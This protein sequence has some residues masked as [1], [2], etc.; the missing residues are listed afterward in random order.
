MA[1]SYLGL[2]IRSCDTDINNSIKELWNYIQ[3]KQ[4]NHPFKGYAVHDIALQY[5][6]PADFDEFKIDNAELLSK[7]ITLS[8]NHP[9]ESIVLIEEYEHGDINSYQGI[10]YKAGNI[11]LNE[12]G[13]F[14]FVFKKHQNEFEEKKIDWYTFYERR[15]NS[16]TSFLN[17]NQEDFNLFKDYYEE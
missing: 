16:L 13:D 15:L 14:N 6:N 2:F 1:S 9:N 12:M 5:E 8:S 17:M 10:V 11:L 3:I 7:I 4:L